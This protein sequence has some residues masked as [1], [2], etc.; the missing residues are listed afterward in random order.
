MVTIIK[1][2]IIV[3]LQVEGL[4]RWKDA[5]EKAPEV[6]FLSYPHRH[7]FHICCKKAVAHNDRDIEIIM[8][9]REIVD[10]LSKTYNSNNLNCL[11]FRSQ[12]CE[13]IS[14]EL[15]EKFELT[16]CSVLED[17]ENGAETFLTEI[18]PTI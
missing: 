16:Y 15:V 8:F 14:K 10:Y 13:M 18:Y 2:N 4:H 1:T 12:S 6:G 5:Q 3:N 11:D 17:G 9:K 7:N